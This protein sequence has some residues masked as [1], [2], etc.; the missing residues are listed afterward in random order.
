MARSLNGLGQVSANIIPANFSDLTLPRLRP[1]IFGLMNAV[2]GVS[3][4]LGV[5]LTSVFYN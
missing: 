4:I 1:Q 3:F 5:L 2:I